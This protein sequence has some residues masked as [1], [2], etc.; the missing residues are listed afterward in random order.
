M[1]YRRRE[2]REVS[3]D[4]GRGKGAADPCPMEGGFIAVELGEELLDV[5]RLELGEVVVVV[6]GLGEEEEADKGVGCEG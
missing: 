1:M 2:G 5:C 4:V 6:G 3:F